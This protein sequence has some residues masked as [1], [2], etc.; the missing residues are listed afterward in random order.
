M[1]V[2]EKSMV[3]LIFMKG[4]GK[5]VFVKEVGSIFGVWEMYMLVYGMLGRC[6]VEGL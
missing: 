4:Y 2:G 1:D 6:V 3:I 5:K